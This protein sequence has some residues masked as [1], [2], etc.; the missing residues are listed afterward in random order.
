MQAYYGF[1]ST[2]TGYKVLRSSKWVPWG[3]GR[4]RPEHQITLVLRVSKE[5]GGK[6]KARG[7]HF[8]TCWPESAQS[9]IGFGFPVFFLCNSASISAKSDRCGATSGHFR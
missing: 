6:W 8:C 4:P 3:P 5:S 1:L 9:A 7:L 2:L